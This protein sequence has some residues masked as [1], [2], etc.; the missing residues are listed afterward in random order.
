[1]QLF[2]IDMFKSLPPAMKKTET[3]LVLFTETTHDA[4]P[5]SRKIISKDDLVFAGKFTLYDKM[6]AIIQNSYV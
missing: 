5:F 1:M 4:L 2:K 6:Y 3:I